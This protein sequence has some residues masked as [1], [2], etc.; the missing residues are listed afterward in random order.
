MTV[1]TKT[2][3][4]IVGTTVCLTV[5]LYVWSHDIVLRGFRR[6]E[7]QQVLRNVGRAQDAL[8]VEIAGMGRTVGDWAPWDDSYR[9][10]NGVL[11]GLRRR[12]VESGTPT[13][14]GKLAAEKEQ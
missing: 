6:L 7:E 4:I 12:A 8:R 3:L 2:L 11:D 9:F 10:V 5:I 13:Q 1:R 14:A